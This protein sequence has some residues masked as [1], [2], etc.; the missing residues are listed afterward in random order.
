MRIWLIGS[1]VVWPIFLRVEDSMVC[2]ACG[3]ISE[4]HGQLHVESPDLMIPLGRGFGFL[5]P[6]TVLVSEKTGGLLNIAFLQR[7]TC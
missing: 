2:V 4:L 1:S 3:S 6:S 7:H 5:A